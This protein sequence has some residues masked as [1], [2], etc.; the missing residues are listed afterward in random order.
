MKTKVLFVSLAA[1]LAA[2]CG[3]AN[4]STAT[5]G[6][7]TTTIT[8]E[9]TYLQRIALIPGGTAT[10][11]LVDVS[12]QDVSAPVIGETT[13]ELVDQQV[14]I[15]FELS[16]DSS[17]DSE[18][19]TFALQATIHGPTG[20]LEW[21]T[22]TTNDVD[23]GQPEVDMGQL[24]LVQ[25]M[26]S[27]AADDAGSSDGADLVGEWNVTTIDGAAI[28]ADTT[29]TLVFGDDRNLGGNSSCNSYSTEYTA[30]GSTLKLESQIAA[31]MMAC[32]PEIGTQE[33]AFLNLLAEVASFEITD[34]NVLTLTTTDGA[35]IEATR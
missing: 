30:S 35:T 10:I 4:T 15:P 3:V 19:A 28:I 2:G 20:D 27:V 9:L 18:G 29:P 5:T 23:L 13:I 31:T 22:D 6:G 11:T 12:L 25:V 14:P 34:G 7:E 8:G 33:S 32:A 21:T 16:V 1:I 17:A 26:P 24:V